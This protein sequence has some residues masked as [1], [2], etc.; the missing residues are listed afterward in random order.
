MQI[1]YLSIIKSLGKQKR[2]LLQFSALSYCDVW[3][4]TSR[5]ELLPE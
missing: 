4:C 1:L 5:M 3:F 2:L